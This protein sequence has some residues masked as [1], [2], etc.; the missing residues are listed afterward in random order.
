MARM[1]LLDYY[2][3]TAASGLDISG[4]LARSVRLS[5]IP[6]AAFSPDGE[7]M[8]MFGVM[9]IDLM[10]NAAVPWLIGTTTLD[11]FP[12]ALTRGAR[13]Y[14]AQVEQQYP[15]LF[16]YVDERNAPSVKWLRRLGFTIDPPASFGVEGLP[17]HRFHK[18][19]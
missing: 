1:R 9:P 6:G 7:L 17:F 14:L 18:G 15:R 10:G 12:G 16:N 2:E 19:L 3:M 8:C 4:T 5:Y 13:T 11:R